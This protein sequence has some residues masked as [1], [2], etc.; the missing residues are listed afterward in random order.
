MLIT[1]TTTLPP[2]KIAVVLRGARPTC[3]IA[4]SLLRT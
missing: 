1:G 2:H 3:I 4:N